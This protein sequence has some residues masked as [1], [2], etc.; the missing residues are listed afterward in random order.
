MLEKMSAMKCEYFL[1]NTKDGDIYWT[2]TDLPNT[3]K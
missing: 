2:A 3:K 1:L